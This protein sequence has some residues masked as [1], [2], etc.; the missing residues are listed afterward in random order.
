MIR[1]PLVAEPL[2]HLG[3]IPVTGPVVTTWGLIAVLLILAILATRRLALRPTRVQA[4]V[5][6]SV[7]RSGDRVRITAQLIEADSDRHL[8]AKSY[9]RASRDILDLQDELARDIANEIK[10]TLTPIDK[11]RHSRPN[12]GFWID[13]VPS[14]EP[15]IPRS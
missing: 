11:K 15:T 7:A 9:E 8:W 14:R 12:K 6:G 13:S 2:F 1:S 5:E 10:V 4:I 3:P